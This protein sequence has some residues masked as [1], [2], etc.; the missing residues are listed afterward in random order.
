M[1]RHTLVALGGLLA[2]FHGWLLGSQL[3]A[4]QLAEPGLVLRWAIAAGLVAALIGLRRSGGAMFWGR[5]AVCIWLL[6]ALLHAPAMAGE[7]V[8]Y[9]S[10]ALPEAVT[11][12]IQIAAA[13]VIVGLGLVLFAALGGWLLARLPAAHRP[14]LAR[15]R[16]AAHLERAPHVA[17]RPPPGPLP[18]TQW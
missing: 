1:L 15:A 18:F 17:P 8:G 6:A 3:W 11:A 12:V 2:L 9:E 4:G 16:G 13:S 5:K 7:Q 10:P 14:A